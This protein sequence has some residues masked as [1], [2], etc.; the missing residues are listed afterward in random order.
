MSNLEYFTGCD[1]KPDYHARVSIQLCELIEGGFFDLSDP[2]WSFPQFSPEQH[3]R[4]CDKI[5]DRYYYREIGV[6]PAGRF[7]LA[8]LRKLNEIMP[9]YIPLYQMLANGTN[10]MQ[11][12]DDYGKSRDVRSDFPQAQLNGKNQDYASSAND[13]EYEDIKTGDWMERAKL[14]QEQYNDIDVMILD[15]LEVCFS[16]LFSVNMNGY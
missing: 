12:S 7:K 14:V 5:V 16:Q 10:I 6:L 4:L 11:V 2:T 9:K 15:E 1:S 13:R 3:E 8:F